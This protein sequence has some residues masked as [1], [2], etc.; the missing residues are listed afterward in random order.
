L[1][2]DYRLKNLSKESD[3]AIYG[4]PLEIGGGIKNWK[5]EMGID[6]IARIILQYGFRRTHRF[7]VIK[8]AKE[9]LI[10]EISTN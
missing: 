9:T 7:V 10:H 6:G 1:C 3:L 4:Y 2:S 8:E 5:E